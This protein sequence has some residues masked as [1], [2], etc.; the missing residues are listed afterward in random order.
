MGL[1]VFDNDARAHNFKNVLNFEEN[2]IKFF[3]NRLI[4]FVY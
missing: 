1:Q 4:C 3:K 2:K